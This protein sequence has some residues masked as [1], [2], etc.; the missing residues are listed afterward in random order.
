MLL[1]MASC[2]LYGNTSLSSWKNLGGLIRL[3]SVVLSV[4]LIDKKKLLE[5]AQVKSYP[6][7][8]AC[9]NVAYN[10]KLSNK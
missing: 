8:V 6:F 4:A 1:P 5:K 9:N 7:S 2:F 3:V 10:L